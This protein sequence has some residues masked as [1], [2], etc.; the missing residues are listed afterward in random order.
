MTRTSVRTSDAASGLM[1]DAA[2][3]LMCG[4][5]SGL[6]C[7]AVNPLTCDVANHLTCVGVN[8][9][10]KAVIGIV[11]ADPTPAPA[12]VAITCCRMANA[13]LTSG[14]EPSRPMSTVAMALRFR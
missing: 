10:T 1:C 14:A 8:D 2:S 12:M 6:M 11:V 4:A 13:G 7:G 5:A 9:R 3:G